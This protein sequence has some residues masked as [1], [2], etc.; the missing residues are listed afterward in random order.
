MKKW[1][2]GITAAILLLGTTVFGVCAEGFSFR[3]I[4]R[5]WF[6]ENESD[7]SFFVKWNSAEAGADVLIED[8]VIGGKSCDFELDSFRDI[9]V[10][11]TDLPAGVYPSVTYEYVTALKQDTYVSEIPLVKKGT[12]SVKLTAEFNTDGS[13]TVTATSQNGLPIPNYALRLTV[14]RMANINGTTDTTGKF[15]SAYTAAPGEA[16]VFEGIATEYQ[17]VY[18][19]AVPPTKMTRP[20]PTTTTVPTTT[21]P[22]TTGGSENTTSSGETTTVTEET[23]STTAATTSSPVQEVILPVRGAGTTAKLD[24]GVALNIS[25]DTGILEL[26]GVDRTDFDNRARLI[27]SQDAY[28]GM[29]GRTPNILMLN[30]LSAK[31][32][33]THSALEETLKKSSFAG[34][35]GKEWS[36]LTFNLSL[37]MLD[38]TG[39]V[40]PVTT[41]PENVQYTVELPIPSSMKNC[42]EWAI[43]TMD[44]NEFMTPQRLTV[45]DGCF[46]I[47]T[48]SMGDYTIIGFSADANDK[49]GG[50]SWRLVFLLIFGI[51]LLAG[52]GVLLYF[53]VLRKPAPQPE[54]AQ[55]PM[56]FQPES[57]TDFSGSNEND[58]FS[59]RT[60]MD[61]FPKTPD[62]NK[63][64]EQE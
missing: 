50:I 20:A 3:E 1:I 35:S 17:G 24:K 64:D 38:R 21:A 49:A 29:L 36:P 59:G 30:V 26:F 34:H 54:A 39:N 13:V 9:V 62:N 12:S 7:Y 14:G 33:V 41:V 23:T 28:S 22:T 8:V 15:H 10:D 18:Y 58:I 56:Y 16:A 27:L 48:N 55:T 43:T 42:S 32:Q 19:A 51:L 63:Q 46:R 40:L 44:G 60:D 2:A 37:L 47:Q 5:E 6:S 31:Q 61:A 52:A 11:I 45:T 53:F 25:T 57:D 4:S